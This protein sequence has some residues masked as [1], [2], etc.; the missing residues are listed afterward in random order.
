MRAPPI[1][2]ALN[3]RTPPPPR[4]PKLIPPPCP[5]NPPKCPPPPCPPNPPKCP[6]PPCPPPPPPPPC[7]PPP[8]ASA[9]SVKRGTPRSSIPAK[10]A[11]LATTSLTPRR[12]TALPTPP[13]P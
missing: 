3:E 11:Q 10:Q 7:P 6:P 4:A 9:S 2:A 5:P 1:C 12:H 8:R 13:V